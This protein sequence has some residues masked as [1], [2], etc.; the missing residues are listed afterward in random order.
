MA[1]TSFTGTYE[2]LS[3]NFWAPRTYDGIT[4]NN[5]EAAFQAQKTHEHVIK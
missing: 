2:W 1:I 5:A 4:Y 3:N